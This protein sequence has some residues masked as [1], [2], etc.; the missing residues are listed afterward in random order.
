MKSY[1]YKVVCD[2]EAQAAV[3]QSFT[4]WITLKGEKKGYED[5]KTLKFTHRLKLNMPMIM[6]PAQKLSMIHH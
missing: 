3:L 2:Q 6:S 1:Q 4:T 5:T